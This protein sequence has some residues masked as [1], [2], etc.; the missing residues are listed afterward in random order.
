[1]EKI[2]ENLSYIIKDEDTDKDKFEKILKKMGE[3]DINLMCSKYAITEVK[4]GF[5][6]GNVSMN[7]KE[8]EINLPFILEAHLFNSNINSVI[9]NM[10]KFIVFEKLGVL[11]EVQSKEIEKNTEVAASYKQLNFINDKMKYNDKKQI[12]DDK[13]KEFNKKIENLSKAEASTIITA[14]G[15]K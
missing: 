11:H 9:M 5:C 10:K 3:H 15:R 8:E 2:K 1:M 13:L 12:V 7:I 14:L 6:I 4:E